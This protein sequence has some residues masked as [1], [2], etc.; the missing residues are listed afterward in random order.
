M[1]RWTAWPVPSF[2]Q[3]F[4]AMEVEVCVED[5]TCCSRCLL[6]GTGILDRISQEQMALSGPI[7]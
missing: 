6:P 5:D 7:G 2:R 4:A 1:R 3:L